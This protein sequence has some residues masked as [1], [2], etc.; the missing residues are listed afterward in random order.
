MFTEEE[1]IEWVRRMPS[2][3][4]G[5][6]I[7]RIKALIK[8]RDTYRDALHAN[9]VGSHRK[10]LDDIAEDQR[11]L[12]SMTEETMRAA[13]GYPTKGAILLCDACMLRKREEDAPAIT[14]EGKRLRMCPRCWV[15][16]QDIYRNIVGKPLE[17]GAVL[18]RSSG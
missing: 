5:R 9:H 4:T 1:L 16:V 2:T 15:E 8:E 10:R 12:A 13:A 3:Q 14:V 17:S 18:N 7:G 6:A 11:A